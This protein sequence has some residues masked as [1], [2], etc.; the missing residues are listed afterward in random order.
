MAI[1]GFGMIAA[2]TLGRPVPP[3]MPVTTTPPPQPEAASAVP[4]RDRPTS[5]ASQARAQAQAPASSPSP[6]LLDSRSAPTR[7]DIPSIGVS[8]PLGGVGNASNG[9]IDVPPANKPHLAGWYTPGA[10]PGQPGRTVIVGHLDSRYS[11]AAVFYDLGAVRRGETVTVTRRDGIAVVYRVDGASIQ[12]KDQF[13]VDQIYAPSDRS[14]LRLVTCGGSF[15]KKIGWSDNIIVYAHMISWHR[16]PET[17]WER[18]L[19]DNVS[20]G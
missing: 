6:S 1:S 12:P 18:L 5:A 17:R 15:D 3:P 14:E 9:A 2:D 7:L 8:A 19:R 11:G 20:S 10:T 16:T 4:K 13:P